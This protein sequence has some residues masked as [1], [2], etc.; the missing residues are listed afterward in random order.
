MK[1]KVTFSAVAAL[2]VLSLLCVG[3]ALRGQDYGSEQS[4]KAVV[5]Y[6]C[7]PL[8]LFASQQQLQAVL[9]AQGNAGWKLVGPYAVGDITNPG[10][11]LVFMK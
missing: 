3:A 5:Q 7:V 11:V 6:K 9:T 10:Q 1:R 4:A 8:P 2:L